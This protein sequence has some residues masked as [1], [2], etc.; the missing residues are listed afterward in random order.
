MVTF[1]LTKLVVVIIP[2]TSLTYLLTQVR[3]HDLSYI[4][5]L[6]VVLELQQGGQLMVKT[7]RFI[8]VMVDQV[9]EVHCKE[10]RLLFRT[11]KSTLDNLILSLLK[12]RII[13]D[14]FL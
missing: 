14:P 4:P 5:D 8:T 13:V 7:P 9:Q 2:S 10:Q 6:M 11:I 12:D 1:G 3:Q